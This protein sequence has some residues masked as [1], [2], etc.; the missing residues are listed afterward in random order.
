MDAIKTRRLKKADFEVDFFFM[1]DVEL[2]PLS[3]EP[4]TVPNMLG[5]TLKQCQHIFH[6]VSLPEYRRWNS[7][8][9]HSIDRRRDDHSAI[10]ASPNIDSKDPEFEK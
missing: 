6:T 8:K 3:G 1:V 10:E 9:D 7:A 5:G 2:F 4:E